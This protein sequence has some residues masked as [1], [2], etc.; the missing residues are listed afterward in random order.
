VQVVGLG[1]PEEGMTI[2]G[3]DGPLQDKQG[4]VKSRLREAPLR[5]IARMTSGEYVPGR[6]N[7]VPLGR[8]YLDHVARLPTRQGDSDAL[9]VY[10][11]RQAWFLAPAFALLASTLLISDRR[12]RNRSKEDRS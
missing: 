4:P 6:T 5:E 3:P 12:R 1:D 2:P 7:L 8:V 11:Q 10:H 9:P